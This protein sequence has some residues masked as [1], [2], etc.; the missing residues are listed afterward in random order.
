MPEIPAEWIEA[1]RRAALNSKAWAAVFEAGS[2]D[3]IVAD[4]LAA[5]LPLIY[6]EVDGVL[7]PVADMAALYDAPPNDLPDRATLGAVVTPDR[8]HRLTLGELRAARAFRDKI[9][10]WVR[11]ADDAWQD[12]EKSDAVPASEQGEGANINVVIAAMFQTADSIES[13]LA[14]AHWRP[15]AIK[16]RQEA[17]FNGIEALRSERAAREKA[18]R[19]RDEARGILAGQLRKVKRVVG[20]YLRRTARPEEPK[21]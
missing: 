16:E 4:V 5:V 19:E 9:K 7:E 11:E 6:R 12:G 20:Q 1:G 15:D 17:I 13:G 8:E 18:E 14:E 3:I 21:P 10:P 2:A